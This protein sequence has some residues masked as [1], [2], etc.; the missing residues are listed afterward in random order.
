MSKLKDEA[1]LAVELSAQLSAEAAQETQAETLPPPIECKADELSTNFYYTFGKHETF[2]AQMTVRGNPGL[3]EIN[4][5]LAAAIDAMKLVVDAGGHAKPVGYQAAGHSAPAPATSPAQ[6]AQ[7]VGKGNIAPAPIA[8][9]P[10]APQTGGVKA[11]QTLTAVKMSVAPEA[12]G[13]VKVAFYE[14]GHQY[15]DIYSTRPVAYWIALLAP[16]GAWAPEHFSAVAEF[17]VAVVVSY[18]LSDKLNSK[19]NAYK[20]I[21]GVKLA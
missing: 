4:A 6:A 5:H 10:A 12:G 9:A 3:D 1:D 13:K 2:N 11:V 14:A 20:D 19:G 15:P 17:G 16:T 8:P 18:T 7:E 21:V